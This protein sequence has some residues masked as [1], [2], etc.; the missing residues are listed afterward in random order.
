VKRYLLI[1]A[2]MVSPAFAGED[3]SVVAKDDTV[4]VYPRIP[5]EEEKIEALKLAYI[6]AGSSFSG[7]PMIDLSKPYMVPKV[8][9]SVPVEPSPGVIPAKPEKRA[10]ADICQRHGRRKVVTGSSWRCVK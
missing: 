3:T 4:W 1:L 5:S 8:I 9:Q 10:N 7:G 2:F 6:L